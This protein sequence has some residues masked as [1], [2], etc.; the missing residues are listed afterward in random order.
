M[1]Q[2]LPVTGYKRMLSRRLAVMMPIMILGLS[3][4]TMA[5]ADTLCPDMS[6]GESSL[7]AGNMADLQFDIGR[8]NLCLQRARLLQQ[9]DETV[10]KREQLRQE[11]LAAPSMGTGGFAGIPPLAAALPPLPSDSRALQNNA[12]PRVQNS[13]P[14]LETKITPQGEWKI[15]RIWGQG[16]VMQAQLIKGDVIANIKMGDTLPTG[17][18]VVELSGRGIVLDD[19]KNRQDLSWK[20]DT[21]AGS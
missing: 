1:R 12:A 8:L 4:A 16:N 6:K 13:A 15:Q 20:E 5:L 7:T 9:I 17:E 11:P 14:V 3:F 18:K 21:K 2:D 10:K 19:G